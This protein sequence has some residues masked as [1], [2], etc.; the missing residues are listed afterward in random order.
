MIVGRYPVIY[1]SAPFT[2][3]RKVFSFWRLRSETSHGLHAEHLYLGRLGVVYDQAGKARIVATTNWWIQSSF[4]GLHDSL[5]KLLSLIPHDGTFDQKA[6]LDRV[7]SNKSPLHKLSGY[8]LSAA[9]DRL[10]IHLQRDILIALGIDGQTWSDLLDIPWFTTLEGGK[11]VRYAVGQP[12]GA[13][14]SWAMLALT[15]HVIV[16]VSYK[17]A[18]VDFREANYAVLGDDMV[19]NHDDVGSMY[20][21]VMESLGLVIKEGK[22]VISHRF[23]EFAKRL[24]GP[25]LDLTPVGAGAILAACRSG[26]MF[27]ALIKAAMGTAVTSTQDL[28]DLVNR[29]PAGLVAKRDLQK[30]VN[31][32]LWQFFGP[33]ASGKVSPVHF[34]SML[35]E[36]I[37]GLPQTSAMLVEYIYDSISFVRFNKQYKAIKES[38]HVPMLRLIIALCT[39]TVSRVPFLRVL[40]TLM[41]FVNP[42]FW[43]Y[44]YKA[45]M[46]ETTFWEDQDKYHENIP[47]VHEEGYIGTLIKLR[48]LL[49]NTP[50]T[51]IVEVPLTKAETQLRATFFRDILADMNQRY[52]L[53]EIHVLHRNWY[54]LDHHYGRSDWPDLSKPV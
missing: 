46:V 43:V 35:L 22:S 37:S 42:G 4:H 19:V 53:S 24:Q 11:E 20:V 54:E 7:V 38:S 47:V 2:F 26:Y 21:R 49:A 39:I 34:G 12:M 18:G 52:K 29:V 10:P 41:L 50:E 5:F 44:F 15:H 31:L 33:T 13:Y 32:V 30:F 17:W 16:Y 40:E 8:D 48:Y 6:A 45:I 14:S 25:S 3:I 9:T 1:Y 23:T 28:L 36:W 27:P 51:S